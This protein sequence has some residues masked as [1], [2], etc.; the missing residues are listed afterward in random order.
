MSRH[1]HQR[2]PQAPN[3]PFNN[4]PLPQP[5]VDLP[6]PDL[7]KASRETDRPFRAG[8]SSALRDQNSANHATVG[9]ESHVTVPR[10]IVTRAIVILNKR[11][12]SLSAHHCHVPLR[13]RLMKFGR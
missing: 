9:S 3:Q 4:P 10:A 12:P 13:T 5:Q 7:T 2:L 8:S 6:L 1:H 11:P